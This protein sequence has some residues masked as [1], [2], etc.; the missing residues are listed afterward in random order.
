MTPEITS[1][2]GISRGTKIY[3]PDGDIE[4]LLKPGRQSGHTQFRIQYNPVSGWQVAEH[5]IV[6]FCTDHIDEDWKGFIV[7]TVPKTGFFCH[8]DPFY[9]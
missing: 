2:E 3:R 8:V 7:K 1:S 5:G 9:T 4:K 6:C